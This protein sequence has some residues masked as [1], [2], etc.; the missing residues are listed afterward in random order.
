[1]QILF[2]KKFLYCLNKFI[3][4][5]FI[6]V[7]NKTAMLRVFFILILISFSFAVFPQHNAQV[8]SILNLKKSYNFIVRSFV[9]RKFSSDIIEKELLVEKDDKI[10]VKLINVLCWNNFNINPLKALTYA[11][12]QMELAEKIQDKDAIEVGYD[13][14]GFLYSNLGE[15]ENSITYHLKSLKLK[16]ERGDSADIAMCMNGIG[17]LYF[18]MEHYPQALD[19]MLDELKIESALRKT[20]NL[21]TN[22]SNIGECYAN[23]N[24][25]EKALSFYLLAEKSANRF[26]EKLESNLLTNI[27]T[28]YLRKLDYVKAAEYLGKSLES[29]KESKDA[30][31]LVW[32]DIALAKLFASQNKFEDALKYGQNALVFAQANKFKSESMQASNTLA[33][34]YSK[35]KNFQKAFEYQKQY[36]ELRDTIITESN[37]RAITEMQTKYETEKKQDEIEVQNLQLSKQD[38]E[39]NKKQITIY[40]S[41]G[42]L[43]L[44]VF[45][46]FY[47]YR[48][49]RQKQKANVII[50]LQKEE[51]EK[52]NEVI[53]KQKQIVE[54]KNK[55]ITDS[56]NYAKRIQEAILPARELKRRIFPDAFVLFQPRDIVSG[57][58]YWFAEKNE[59]RIIAAADC[60]GHGVPGAFMSMI[61]NAFLN[62]IINE[63][64]ITSPAEI[65][66]LLRTKVITSLK[67]ANDDGQNNSDGMDIALLSIDDKKNTAEF[68]GANNPVWHI[69]NGIVTEIKG[70][71]QPIGLYRGETQP[72]TN[73]KISFQ[74]GDSLYIFTDGYADQFGGEKGKKFRYKQMQ[75]VLLSIQNREMPAQEKILLDTFYK[76]KGN[77]EQVD[78]VLV[79]GINV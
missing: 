71:K 56:I 35:M 72:F 68:A 47:I 2:K 59:K 8:D 14:F 15:Y 75:E 49:Y 64:G 52:K 51:V 23:M 61:G 6:F 19:Y 18:N 43:T 77:L 62:E 26:G 7:L 24:Q 11:K 12:M 4:D 63:N 44:V 58:F 29:A 28:S 73:H 53:E 54:E 69:R 60:T 9:D 10:R 37:T 39:L 27:G 22:Y 48:G 31:D 46:T 67:Q 20:N 16:E 41:L 50:T 55:D 34:V 79:I 21:V 74:K 38:L 30:A 3:F 42:G 13:N 70:D 40:A 32:A 66:N 5:L 33:E 76:W 36:S 1:M 25:F 17:S 65:L 45:L 78:D 57:D